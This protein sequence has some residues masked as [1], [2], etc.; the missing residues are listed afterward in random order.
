[1]RG[2]FV[3]ANGSVVLRRIPGDVA[4]EGGYGEIGRAKIPGNSSE[5]EVLVVALPDPHAAVLEIDR[6]FL[7]QNAHR[8]LGVIPATPRY[9]RHRS[10]TPSLRILR[11]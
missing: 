9:C 6:F 3:G 5:H 4:V 2:L 8:F 7:Y 11:P 1:M 10:C